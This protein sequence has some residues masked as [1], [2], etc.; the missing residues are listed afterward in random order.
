M[1]VYERPATDHDKSILIR[2]AI[3]IHG[4]TGF[5]RIAAGGRRSLAFPVQ[6]RAAVT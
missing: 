5:E 4:Q 2:A 6:D 1:H 3:H